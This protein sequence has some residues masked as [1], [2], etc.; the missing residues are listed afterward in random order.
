MRKP[1]TLK[2]TAALEEIARIRRHC[3]DPGDE[4]IEKLILTNGPERALA[5]LRLAAYFDLDR[6]AERC[7][8]APETTQ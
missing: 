5:I 4:A 3:L 6:L 1:M 7:D 2:Q 8:R